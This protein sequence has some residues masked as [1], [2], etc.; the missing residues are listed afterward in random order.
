MCTDDNRG[1]DWKCDC[2][3]RILTILLVLGDAVFQAEGEAVHSW[4]Y[5]PFISKYLT[6]SGSA[7]SSRLQ[8][9]NRRLVAKLLYPK[10]E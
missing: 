8:P 3:L 4:I 10:A 1:A 7:A 9:Q 6:Y 2:G 5:I